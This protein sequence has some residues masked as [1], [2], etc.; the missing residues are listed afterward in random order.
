VFMRKK[1][2]S[3][4]L[5]LENRSLLEK[6][7]QFEKA[8]TRNSVNSLKEIAR[9]LEEH[10]LLHWQR[11]E[12]SL[13]PEMAKRLPRHGEPVTRRRI[14]AREHGERLKEL[15]NHIRMGRRGE[16]IYQGHMFVTDLRDHLLGAN[17]ALLPL[18]ERL[19]SL[20]DWERVRRAFESIRSMTPPVT[21]GTAASV[22]PSGTPLS[23]GV[24]AS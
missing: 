19:L 3:A 15:R 12:G 4:V 6:L 16:F 13:F 1:G 9:S 11:E 8:L 5:S 10:L 17:N 18:A 20:E 23:L 24:A 21:L 14:K 7:G 22:E 2:M